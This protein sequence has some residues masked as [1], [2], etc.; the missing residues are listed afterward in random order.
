[1]KKILLLLVA[2]CSLFTSCYKDDTPAPNIEFESQVIET[3]FEPAKYFVKVKSTRTWVATTEDEWIVIEKE[4][5]E[6]GDSEVE[7]SVK[8]NEE[9]AER[10][11]R[12]TLTNEASSL[13]AEL[14]VRQKAFVPSIT[15]SETPIFTVEGGTKKV[16]IVANTTYEVS[17]TEDWVSATQENGGSAVRIT[18]KPHDDVSVREANVILRN[19]KYDY[20]VVIAINQGAFVPQ[21]TID[22]EQLQFPFE[23]AVQEISVESNFDF[24]KSLDA[25]WLQFQNDD[26]GAE[27]KDVTLE[28]I[29]LRTTKIK[30]AV[31]PSVESSVRTA[32]LILT[33]EKY[34]VT[35]E[36]V[37]SQDALVP[38]AP[39]VIIYT[40][41]DTKPVPVNR[42][43]RTT[44]VKNTYKD[45]RGV[46][47]FDAADSVVMSSAFRNCT[48][49]TSVVLPQDIQTIDDSAFRGCTALED[50]DIPAKVN[51]I[52]NY[53]FSD[54]SALSNVVIPESVEEMGEGVFSY[55]TDLR[56]IVLPNSIKEI[57]NYTFQGCTSLTS[58][59]IP[60]N[61]EI[62]GRWA[63]ADCMSLM[64]ITIPNSVVAIKEYA[65]YYCFSI[66]RIHLPVGIAIIE[67]AT[68][69]GCS[70]LIDIL[71]P[72]GIV[73]IGNESFKGCS[74]L[75]E[76]VIPRGV[77]L[78]GRSA[79]SGCSSLKR[80]YCKPVTPPDGSEDMFYKNATDRMI[81][82]PTESVEAYKSA[83]YWSAYATSIVAE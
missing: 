11:G 6:I 44:M 19:E 28:D 35:R 47:I 42:I 3:E 73:I 81:Y 10:E 1:M 15:Y 12:I 16:K 36:V 60:A 72:D 31:E 68:F 27:V 55:C 80:V 4:N 7:F 29:S 67:N 39:N 61:V 32:K 56:A 65:F 83:P 74:R 82:V 41:S 52:G 57:N 33:S 45:G 17:T 54:C 38:N 70:S 9:M 8:R 34:N 13:V 58:V 21:I 14:I 46:I 63:F 51:L 18:V 77:N 79:F 59:N 76:I 71:M 30:V 43:F 24:E 5:G 23:G 2:V 49:L 37:I 26:N 25:E 75:G 62:I 66:R 48:T 50:I 78:V 64:E 20:S 40:S 69:Y 53:A 22:K